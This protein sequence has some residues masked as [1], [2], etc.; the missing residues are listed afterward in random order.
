MLI[1][2][3]VVYGKTTEMLIGIPVVYGKTTEMLISTLVV[4]RKT[5]MI[6]ILGKKLYIVINSQSRLARDSCF[7]RK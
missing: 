6:H 3:P 7:D 5:T 4:Y 1:G 2:T